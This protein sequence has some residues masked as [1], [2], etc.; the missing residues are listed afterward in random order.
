MP[1]ITEFSRSV[2]VEINRKKSAD[3][4]LLYVKDQ[5]P[6]YNRDIKFVSQLSKTSNT[7]SFIMLNKT[8]IALACE[9]IIA[10]MQYKKRLQLFREDAIK[11]RKE[12]DQIEKK[13]KPMNFINML[14]NIIKLI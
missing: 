4:V 7:E 6:I 13:N 10:R 1:R 5:D 3:P 11:W 2:A 12:M 14:S 8:N 9:D